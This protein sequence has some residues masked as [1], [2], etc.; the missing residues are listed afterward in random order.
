[1]KYKMHNIY[2][3]EIIKILKVIFI[4]ILEVRDLSHVYSLKIYRKEKGI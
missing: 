1:M 2:Q 4:I 3:I